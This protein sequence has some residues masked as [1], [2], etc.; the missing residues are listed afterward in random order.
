[1]FFSEFTDNFLPLKNWIFFFESRF[2]ITI[3]FLSLISD[4]IFS[5]I[6]CLSGILLF[7]I[8]Y[9]ILLYIYFQFLLVSALF[10]NIRSDINFLLYQFLLFCWLRKILSIWFQTDLLTDHMKQLRRVIRPGSKLLNWSS[11]GISDFVQKSSAVS[12]SRVQ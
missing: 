2:N 7:Q 5:T 8:C 10:V 6:R 1:M 9:N 3:L 11:L 12:T 4:L